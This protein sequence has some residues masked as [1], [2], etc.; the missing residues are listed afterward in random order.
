MR[1][2]IVDDDPQVGRAIQGWLRD[3]G[4][5][6]RLAD[7]SASGLSALDHFGV[8]L[9]IVDVLMPDLRA[10]ESI[11]L[12]HTQAPT[13]PLI[14]IS[15]SV[16]PNASEAAWTRPPELA[17]RLGATR[18]LRKPFKPATLLDVIDEC[19]SQAVQARRNCVRERRDGLKP[20]QGGACWKTAS[21]RPRTAHG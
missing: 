13:V 5:R 8:D 20:L 3:H 17:A 15:G 18:C 19:L 12:F 7:S 16:A 9:M 4:F 1:L 14:A 2:L 11:R 21:G 6:V 10:F